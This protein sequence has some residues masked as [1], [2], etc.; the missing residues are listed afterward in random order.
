[1]K[2]DKVLELKKNRLFWGNPGTGKTTVAA[3]YGR[4]LKA[5]QLLHA[6]MVIS[7]AQH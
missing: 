5:L 2:G 7:S 3:I 6:I 4:I 1:M